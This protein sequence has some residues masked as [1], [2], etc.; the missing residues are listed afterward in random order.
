MTNPFK[1]YADRFSEFGFW[2]T[3]S[4]VCPKNWP[5]GGVQLRFCCSTPIASRKRQAWAKN[6]ILGTLGYLLAP[7]DAIP[8]LSPIIGYT[9]DIGVLSFRAWSPLPGMSMRR[10]AER[11]G[12]GSRSGL[13]INEHA[14]LEEVDK[15]L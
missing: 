4:L 3:L 12:S 15:V 5:E 10:C 11:R 14:E 6:I 13:G 1:K 9:D 2:K 7:F 8:D